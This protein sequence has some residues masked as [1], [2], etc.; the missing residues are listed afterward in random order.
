MADY[1][2]V[3]LA[4]NLAGSGGGD[5]PINIENEAEVVNRSWTRVISRAYRG[6]KE[7]ARKLTELDYGYLV[8]TSPNNDKEMY[9]TEVEAFLPSE[10]ASYPMGTAIQAYNGYL[11]L[12]LGALHMDL[13][14]LGVGLDRVILFPQSYTG[15]SEDLSGSITFAAAVGSL[16][17]EVILDYKRATP[18]GGSTN[19]AWRF[20]IR[21]IT[22]GGQDITTYYSSLDMFVIMMGLALNNGVQ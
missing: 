1:F 2:D 20:T 9:I 17:G 5:T 21:S 15:T 4:R 13:S 3:L 19:N 12:S 7:I 8:S 10:V 16:S 22:M 6:D 14:V 18:P 11:F